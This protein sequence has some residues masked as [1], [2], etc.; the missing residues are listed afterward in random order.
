[1]PMQQMDLSK[2][3]KKPKNY[4]YNSL[5]SPHPDK[6]RD[7]DD[8]NAY[9]DARG[10]GEGTPFIN[11]STNWVQGI[12]EK[13]F[14]TPIIKEVSNDG[15]KMWFSQD[16]TDYIANLT[17]FGVNLIEKATFGQ[18]PNIEGSNGPSKNP[19]MNYNPMSNRNKNTEDG[20]E[21]EEDDNAN[22]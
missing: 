19:Q 17:P 3:A 4:V 21:Y 22:S 5:G 14:L 12:M 1:M 18:G 6:D 15:K 9:A 13:G 16:G 20:L 11:K 2:D 10:D 7:E 8:L